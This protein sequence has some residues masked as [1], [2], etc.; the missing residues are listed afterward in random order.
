MHISDALADD[1]ELSAHRITVSTIDGYQGQEKDVVYLSLVR[2]NEKGAIGFLKDYRR[3]NVAMTRAKRMLVMVGDS[4]TISQDE[5]YSKF[6][7]FVD[8]E[9]AYRSAWEFIQ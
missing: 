2:C 8:K 4:G 7:D 1:A 9:Q 3:M 5:F 6:L